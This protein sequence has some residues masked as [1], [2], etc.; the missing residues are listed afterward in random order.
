MG[1]PIILSKQAVFKV[2]VLYQAI[3]DHCH[4]YSLE[5][6]TDKF[7]TANNFD[8]KSVVDEVYNF[9]LQHNEMIPSS[10]ILQLSEKKFV[11][12]KGYYDRNHVV[13]AEKIHAVLNEGFTLK[14]SEGIETKDE[15]ERQNSLA[16]NTSSLSLS[17][18]SIQ[19]KLYKQ[20]AEVHKKLHKYSGVNFQSEEA[21]ILAS[22]FRFLK[23]N[24]VDALIESQQLTKL[25]EQFYQ[26]HRR[27][28]PFGITLKLGEKT[29]Q[30]F[31]PFDPNYESTAKNIAAISVGLNE[32]FSAEAI[33]SV[34]AI[35]T[36]SLYDFSE[37]IQKLVDGHIGRALPNS[38]EHSNIITLGEVL[39]TCQQA[40]KQTMLASESA[41]SVSIEQFLNTCKDHINFTGNRLSTWLQG[42][43]RSTDSFD[44]NFREPSIA[45]CLSAVEDVKQSFIEL[46]D[47]L[48]EQQASV[49]Y[50]K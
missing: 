4:R 5:E 28:I 31:G 27:L 9:Y 13:N 48:K 39:Q 20:I 50:Q 26:N 19:V 15:A 11:T 34:T 7:I 24:T 1:N 43:E 10:F 32:T 3:H 47:G 44:E 12:G 30:G 23:A 40:L 35:Q 45:A 18:E 46:S 25:V 22:R 33:T 2:A 21:S 29:I 16:V 42:C 36:V 37:Q 6:T 38:P 17:T 41:Y 49:V 14:V 8:I